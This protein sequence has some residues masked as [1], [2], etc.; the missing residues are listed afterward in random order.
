MSLVGRGKQDL[1]NDHSCYF[2]A[3]AGQKGCKLVLLN[4]STLEVYVQGENLP[5]ED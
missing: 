4:E 1:L 3:D 5:S 2:C